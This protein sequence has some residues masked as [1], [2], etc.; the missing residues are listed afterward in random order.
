MKGLMLSLLIVVSSFAVA[1][2]NAKVMY[3]NGTVK[4]EYEKRGD[5]VAVTNY[6]ENGQIKETGF[7]KNGVPE[8]KWESFGTD[9]VKTAEVTYV[10]GQR[11]GEFRVWDQFENAYIEMRYNHG[12]VVAANR[13]LKQTDFAV[14]DK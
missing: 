11:H 5:R 2:D 8:G 12:Q 6:H 3:D 7:F 9:G 4:S 14:K 1:Q 13:Y 10:N